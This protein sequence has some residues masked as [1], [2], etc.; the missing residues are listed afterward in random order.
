MYPKLHWLLEHVVEFAERLR[1]WGLSS[2]QSIEH[3]HA[4]INE[5]ARHFSAIKDR[6]AFFRQLSRLQTARN[7]VFD[8]NFNYN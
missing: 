3:L 1:F 7:F 8:R 6:E 4:L 2:E 5:D